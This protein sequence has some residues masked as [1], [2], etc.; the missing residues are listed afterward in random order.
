MSNL[1]YYTSSPESDNSELPHVTLFC[2]GAAQPNPG[3]TGIGVVLLF[4]EKHRKEFSKTLGYGTNNS[5]EIM[6]AVEGLKA[7]K[8]SCHVALFSDSKYLIE[9]MNGSYR[10]S[11]NLALWVL[12]DVAAERHEIEWKW[13]RGHSGDPNNERANTLAE[14]AAARQDVPLFEGVDG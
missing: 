3:N 12:L 10:R 11:T 8:Q 9:T 13:L 1:T 2:D 7:L 5:A 4:G 6:A 14:T